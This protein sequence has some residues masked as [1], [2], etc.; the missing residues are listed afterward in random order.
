M[1]A[2]VIPKHYSLIHTADASPLRVAGHK[3]KSTVW[4][5]KEIFMFGRVATFVYGVLSYLIF[6]DLPLR[7]RGS[8]VT[9]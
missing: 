3:R 6:L 9:S 5:R 2:G 4:S 1:P 7:S 8:S